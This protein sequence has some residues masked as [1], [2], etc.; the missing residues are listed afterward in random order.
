MTAILLGKNT[1][2]DYLVFFCLYPQTDEERSSN[3]FDD[4]IFKNRFIRKKFNK[5]SVCNQKKEQHTVVPFSFY[6]LVSS[7]E[8]SSAMFAPRVIGGRTNQ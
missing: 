2:C 3:D 6:I 1:R 5:I 8:G 7:N 4:Q